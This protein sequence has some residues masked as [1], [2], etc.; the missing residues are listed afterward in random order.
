MRLVVDLPVE[1]MQS[2]VPSIFKV[3][4]NRK[5]EQLLVFLFFNF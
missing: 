5:P 1:L 4:I 2:N 3:N